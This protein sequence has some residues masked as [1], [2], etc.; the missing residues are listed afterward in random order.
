MRNPLLFTISLVLAASISTAAVA[1]TPS[2]AGQPVDWRITEKEVKAVQVELT[3]RGYYKSKITGVLDRDTREAV[4]AYQTDSGLR[5]NGR[6]DRATYDR[7]GLNYPATGKE[8]ESLRSDGLLPKIGYTVKDKTVATGNA[9]SGG[10]KKAGSGVKTGVVKTL[11][12]SGETVS[13]SMEAVGAA[14]NA[15]VK[16]VKGTGRTLGRAG[17][18]LISRSDKDIQHDVRKVMDD[19]PETELWETQVK[20]GMVTV[21]TPPNHKADVGALISEIRKIVGVKSVFVIAQ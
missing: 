19:N 13:K 17:D 6:V 12:T 18:K 14:G 2:A 7:L 10:A 16:G 11:E 9:I 8:A 1:Q 21:K 5:V 20:N 15:T 3:H 4:T